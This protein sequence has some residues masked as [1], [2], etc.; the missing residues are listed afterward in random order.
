[1]THTDETQDTSEDNADS[2]EAHMTVSIKE[3]REAVLTLRKFFEQQDKAEF[4]LIVQV[5][6]HVKAKSA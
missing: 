1:M 5:D 2:E 6:Q 4:D 3:A